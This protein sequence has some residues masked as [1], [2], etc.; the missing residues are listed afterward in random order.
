MKPMM[1]L[2]LL[3]ICFTSC[4]GSGSDGSGN[5]SASTS[6]EKSI[7]FVSGLQD[8]QNITRAEG[9]ETK[10]TSFNVW[11]Y[12]NDAYDTTNGYTSYQTVFPGFIVNY[13]ASGA[14]ATT[15]NTNGWDYIGQAAD[16][17]IK[18][19][20][21]GAKAYRFFGI[22]PAGSYSPTVSGD[23]VTV[24]FTADASDKAKVDATPF[25]SHLWY[26]TGNLNDYPTRKFGQP[27]LLEFTKPFSVVTVKF[28]DESGYEYIE[29]SIKSF[30]FKPTDS[31]RKVAV[32]GNISISY[33]L[34]GTATQEILTVNNISA[35][36]DNG[37]VG[38]YKNIL[39]QSVLPLTGQGSYTMTLQLITDAENQNH[40]TTVPSEYMNWKV[41]YAYTYIFKVSSSNQVV[42]QA[43]QVGIRDWGVG[44]E[45]NHD[46]YNW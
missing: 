3:L 29:E 1:Y 8:E 26:S 30:S 15:A 44:N 33:P 14:N 6:E 42:L 39:S 34:K 31:Q 40:T 24:T 46:I 12:K 16:Q 36:L 38:T 37:I 41:G 5:T 18:Y 4:S 27:V 7:S 21:W 22:A 32:K 43:V 9:L 19:W 25:Y 17:T 11:G 28:V 2:I 13:I 10:K 20:D 23:D 35:Y 45:V